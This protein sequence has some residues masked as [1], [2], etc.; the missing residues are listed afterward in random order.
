MSRRVIKARV[1]A[2]AG[3]EVRQES[4]KIGGSQENLVYVDGSGVYIV[5]PISILSEPENIRVGSSW[6]FPTANKAS[7]PSTAVNPQAILESNSPVSGFSNFAQEV[8][9]FLGE[10]L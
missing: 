10:I 8:A 5:G 9:R 3:I 6:T 2:P 4:V 1:D 7:L